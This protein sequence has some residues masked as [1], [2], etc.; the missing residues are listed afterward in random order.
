MSAV[1]TRA[2]TI[3]AWPSPQLERVVNPGAPSHSRGRD[4]PHRVS[5]LG[6]LIAAHWPLPALGPGQLHL[7]CPWR[8]PE[9]IHT[10]LARAA[11]SIAEAAVSGYGPRGG[12]LF[13]AGDPVPDKHSRCAPRTAGGRQPETLCPEGTPY[14]SAVRGRLR[15]PNA[16]D[17]PQQPSRYP[18][19]KRACRTLGAHSYPPRWERFREGE[20]H[21]GTVG[22]RYQRRGPEAS[23]A[24]RRQ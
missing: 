3:A 11:T 6:A 2:P 1:G 12:L 19:A 20:R 8:R 18:F 23:P 9:G 21:D 17:N 14:G 15:L 16:G 5:A 4:G 7:A 24:T 22:S 13:R 10:R